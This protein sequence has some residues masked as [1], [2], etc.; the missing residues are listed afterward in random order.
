MRDRIDDL[1]DVGHKHD[2]ADGEHAGTRVDMHV[3]RVAGERHVAGDLSAVIGAEFPYH[4]DRT[5]CA[6]APRELLER[7]AGA[8]AYGFETQA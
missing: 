6:R 2:V 8:F 3:D 1:P 5:G 7:I 4:L